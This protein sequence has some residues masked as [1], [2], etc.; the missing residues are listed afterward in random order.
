MQKE[1][2]CLVYASHSDNASSP[3]VLN[4][5][6]QNQNQNSLG[7]FFGDRFGNCGGGRTSRSGGRGGRY[8]G[9]RNQQRSDRGGEGGTDAPYQQNWGAPWQPM[10]FNLQQQQQCGLLP[11]TSA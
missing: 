9:G 6:H 5:E 7:N 1:Q 8:G 2:F 4:V 3:T 10:S 11:Y